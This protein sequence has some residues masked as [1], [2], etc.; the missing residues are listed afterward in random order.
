MLVIIADYV[1]LEITSANTATVSL[2]LK[3][4]YLDHYCSQ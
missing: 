2:I 3:L 4:F 1:K